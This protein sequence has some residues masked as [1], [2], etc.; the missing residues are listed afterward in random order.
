MYYVATKKWFP[1]V[2]DSEYTEE[3]LAVAQFLEEEY[4][5]KM[6]ISVA[7]GISLAFGGSKE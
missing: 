5:D 1:S 6:K 7:N 2:P 3:L 4:W